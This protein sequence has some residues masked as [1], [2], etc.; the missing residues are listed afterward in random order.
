MGDKDPKPLEG[1]SHS[2]W[3]RKKSS[4]GISETEK[5]KDASARDA[6]L[7]RPPFSH[8]YG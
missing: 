3:T 6:P 5:K 1:E 2:W 4:R 8:L 7:R